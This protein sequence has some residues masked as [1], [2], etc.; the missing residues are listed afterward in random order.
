MSTEEKARRTGFEVQDEL[1]QRKKTIME[2]LIPERRQI[3]GFLLGIIPLF[4]LL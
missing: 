1:E 4:V 3:L 2:R